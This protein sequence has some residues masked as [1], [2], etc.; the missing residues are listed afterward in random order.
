MS[1]LYPRLL[2]RAASER[3]AE[4]ASVEH[5]RDLTVRAAA[6]HPAAVFAATGGR[7]VTE[8]ELRAM[9][10]DVL[11]LAAAAGYPDVA[12]SG[13]R[14]TFDVEAAK[15]LYRRMGLVPAEASVRALWAFVALVLLPDVAYWRFPDPPKDR[16]LATDI[17]RHVFGRLW[18]RAHL[19]HD[20]GRDEPFALLDTFGEAAFDQI[21]ARRRA[22]GGSRALIRG[23]AAHWPAAD[24]GGCSERDV[25][26]ETLKRLLRHGAFQDF[27]CLEPA[28]I[29]DEIAHVVG[30]VVEALST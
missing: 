28:V 15:L 19:L 13:A 10:D 24:R 25:L 26:R 20:P 30:E 5:A 18:W 4:F 23:L 12:A 6:R 11:A 27:E 7:R 16:V 22:L 8:G 2:D 21:F 1:V 17:T 29:R 9:R 14:A 3:F